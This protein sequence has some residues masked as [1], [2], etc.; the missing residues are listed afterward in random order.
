MKPASTRY[1]LSLTL[2]LAAIA[3]VSIAYAGTYGHRADE[4]VSESPPPMMFI[5]F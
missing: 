1:T 4:A 3:A 5:P 2:I